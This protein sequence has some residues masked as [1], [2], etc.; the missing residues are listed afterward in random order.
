MVEPCLEIRVICIYIFMSRIHTQKK[1]SKA[2]SICVQICGSD[3]DVLNLSASS[4][5][6]DGPSIG[7]CAKKDERKR[8]YDDFNPLVRQSECETHNVSY[9]R[10]FSM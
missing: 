2:T 5:L 3:R 9:R 6:S 8:I 10:D 4:H 1:G 7:N